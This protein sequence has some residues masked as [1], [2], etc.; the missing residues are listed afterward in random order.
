MVRT[1]P[2]WIGLVCFA[3]QGDPDPVEVPGPLQI[4]AI[5]VS[6]AEARVG[7]RLTCEAQAGAGSGGAPTL[8]YA[9]STG[10][11][12]STLALTA[13]NTTV[14]GTITCT[15]T[16]SQSGGATASATASATILNS[17]PQL[18]NAAVTP[19]EARVGDTLTCSATATDPDQEAVEVTYAWSTGHAGPN[20]TLTAA[21]TTVGEPVICTVTAT[22]PHGDVD[23]RE[24]PATVLNTPPGAPGL[25]LSPSPPLA[26][27]PLRCE[28]SIP[29]D[30]PDDEDVTYTFAWSVDGAPFAGAAHQDSAS[31]VPE[32]LIEA[33]QEWRCTVTPRDPHEDGQPMSALGTAIIP[34]CVDGS[35][36]HVEGT[37]GA[38]EGQRPIEVCDEQVWEPAGCSSVRLSLRATVTSIPGAPAAPPDLAVGDTVDFAVSLPDQAEITAPVMWRCEDN[39]NR[40]D[41]HHQAWSFDGGTFRVIYSSGHQETGEFDRVEVRDG[42]RICEEVAGEDDPR[43]TRQPDTLSFQLRDRQVLYASNFSGTWLPGPLPTDL[44]P[45]LEAATLPS[46][47]AFSAYM[48]P[49]REESWSTQ[50]RDALSPNPPTS[51]DLTAAD[52]EV[53]MVRVGATPCPGGELEQV[54][55]AG[56]WVD[57][58]VCVAP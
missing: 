3:C 51:L 22:D 52:C 8:S 29:S 16:A 2:G 53:G 20:L 12:G 44:Y 7:T 23:T 38:H 37:C 13:A 1:R 40:E 30:D 41:C 21:D 24:V 50:H 25:V 10:D 43:C 56:A 36:R 47:F 5:S 33:G 18:S 15:A 57:T 45:V 4:T 28:V 39:P 49:H 6:P 9:W 34:P 58:E 48:R 27:L 26:G 46:T 55:E 11:E 17:P 42:G 19:P 14:G 54:C 35:V 32:G 31:E